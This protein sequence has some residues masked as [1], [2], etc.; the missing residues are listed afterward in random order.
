MTE[1]NAPH[2]KRIRVGS[3]ASTFMNGFRVYSTSMIP[4]TMQGRIQDFHWG[5][6][7]GPGGAILAMEGG[8]PLPLMVSMHYSKNMYAGIN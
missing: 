8:T 6:A 2:E 7:A 4:T 5:G 3:P 1:R